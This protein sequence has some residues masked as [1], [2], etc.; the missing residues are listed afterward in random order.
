MSDDPIKHFLMCL[1]AYA[2]AFIITFGHAAAHKECDQ[3]KWQP[4]SEQRAGAGLI[5]ALFW[6]LYWSLFA[7]DELEAKE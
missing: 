7:F 5:S 6:P 3:R 1:A 4:C 2:A